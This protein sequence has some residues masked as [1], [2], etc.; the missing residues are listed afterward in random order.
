MLLQVES[1]SAAKPMEIIKKQS[2]EVGRREEGREQGGREEMGASSSVTERREKREKETLSS[3]PSADI[4]A[5]SSGSIS[6]SLPTPVSISRARVNAA[7]QLSAAEALTLQK[8]REVQA[9]CDLLSFLSFFL[10][11]NC[12]LL[13][14]II[15]WLVAV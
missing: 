11:Q 3:L 15:L 14:S 9:R 8:Q 2:G 1:I 7:P 4:L 13:F 10:P 6:H 12:P 5:P